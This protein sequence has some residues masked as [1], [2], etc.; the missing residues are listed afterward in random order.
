VL[1]WNRPARRPPPFPTYTPP[2]MS[3]LLYVKP[4]YTFLRGSPPTTFDCRFSPWLFSRE[5]SL[6]NQHVLW[7]DIMTV[8]LLL[9]QKLCLLSS[10]CFSAPPLPSSPPSSLLEVEAPLQSFNFPLKEPYGPRSSVHLFI[11]TIF[12]IPFLVNPSLRGS[13]FGPRGEAATPS[14]VCTVTQKYARLSLRWTCPE[15]RCL[16]CLATLCFRHRRYSPLST[17]LLKVAWL[18]Y[19]FPYP[20]IPS[21]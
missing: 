14:P 9:T 2:S 6:C 15:R 19:F 11:Q 17:R 7:G 5:S 20:D 21:R 10:C 4:L 13:S 1:F 18:L 8:C 16:L 3:L 12:I